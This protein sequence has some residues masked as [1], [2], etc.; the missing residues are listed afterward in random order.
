MEKDMKRYKFFLLI[1]ESCFFIRK[2]ELLSEVGKKLSYESDIGLTLEI[3]KKNL[4]ELEKRK[5]ENASVDS[6]EFKCVYV[7]LLDE[8]S[9]DPDYVYAPE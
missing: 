3:E 9:K 2:D 8:K 6:G 4:E 1:G 7:H 5:I